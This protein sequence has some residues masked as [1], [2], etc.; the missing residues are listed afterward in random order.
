MQH[1][2]L[3]VGGGDVAKL[4]CRRRPRCRVAGVVRVGRTRSRRDRVRSRRSVA[5]VGVEH[6]LVRADLGR[7]TDRDDHAVV[8]DV[9]RGAYVHHETDVVID[10]QH[11]HPVRGERV[12]QLGEDLRLAVTQPRRRFVEQQQARP[13]REGAAELAQPGEPGRKGIGSLV[14]HGAQADQVED[15]LGVV[16]RIR[17]EVVRPPASD[18][19]RDENV[20]AGAEAAEHLELLE[21]AR[22]AEASPCRRRCVR[23]VPPCE[24]QGA[25]AQVLQAGDRVED[26]RLARPVRT[27]QPGDAAAFDVEIDFGDRVVTTEPNG[28]P[29]G[30]KQCHCTPRL[31]SP[32]RVEGRAAPS[33]WRDHSGRRAPG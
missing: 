32:A 33:R 8:D 13:R 28:E 22:H 4:E 21:R 20:L 12:Q 11:R 7:R 19:G 26:R 15:R 24:R 31:R 5:Q 25:V 27:D 1:L 30:F 9:D 6:G 10:E 29:A 17:P 3:S 16:A 18:L 23:D 2:D 14:G